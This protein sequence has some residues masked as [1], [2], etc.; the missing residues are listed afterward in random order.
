MG[1]YLQCFNR[2]NRDGSTFF[3]KEM[4]DK[5]MSESWTKLK[6]NIKKL[7]L[8]NLLE[9]HDFNKGISVTLANL[10]EIDE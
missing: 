10:D 1:T 7:A 3:S 4:V 6:N 9:W 8:E 5:E 2:A